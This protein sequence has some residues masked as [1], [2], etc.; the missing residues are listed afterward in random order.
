MRN[1]IAGNAASKSTS[2]PFS[3]REMVIVLLLALVICGIYLQVRA[4]QFINFD[5]L[6]YIVENRNIRD[7][8]SLEGIAWAFRLTSK[9]DWSY[10]HPIT[11]LSHMLDIELFGL[12][13][14]M[15]HLM[16]VLYHIINTTALFLVLRV[17]T[18]SLWKSG[19]VAILFGIHPVNV[20]TVAWIAERK[21][22]LSTTFWITLIVAYSSY[23]KRPSLWRYGLVVILFI[24]GLLT[25]PMLVTLP[26]V[27]LLLDYWPLGR[28]SFH[29]Q[30]VHSFRSLPGLILE[31]V[32]L[33]ALA[34]I[35]IMY[36]M[37]SMGSMNSIIGSHIVPMDLRIKNALVSYLVYL[38]KA[39]WPS[40]LTVFYPFPETIPL[41]EALTALGI[42]VAITTAGIIL[43]RRYP[44]LI[45]GWLWFLGTLLP[46]IGIIQ[47][48][49][50]PAIAERWA[51]VPYIGLFIVFAWGM[52]DCLASCRQGRAIGTGL[53]IV[54]IAALSVK[55]W[56]QT[57]YWKDDMTLF[58]HALEVDRNNPLAHQT[59]GATLYAQGSTDKAIYHYREAVRIMPSYEQAHVCLGVALYGKGMVNEAIQEYRHA[60][61]LNPDRVDT[62]YNL[63]LA[64][65]DAG[66]INE[67]TRE[68]EAVLQISPGHP[69][70]HNNLGFILARQGRLD[71]A[72][73]HYYKALD[74]RQSFDKARMNLVDAF[75]EKGEMEKGIGLMKEAA[76][77]EPANPL[78][79]IRLAEIYRKQ[80]DIVNATGA[81]E[82]ALSADR[83][84]VQ[85]LHG[86][87]VLYAEQRRYD[88]AMDMM[89]RLSFLRP[90]DPLVD[91]NISCLYARQ[92]KAVEAV[93]FI[94]K[95]MRKGFNK[96]DMLKN[97]PDLD[98][99]RD[100]KPFKDAISGS[101]R[102][103][104]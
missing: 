12:N 73:H 29:H 72:I 34:F 45:V 31:K 47:S 8:L 91:Y 97:D 82:Q 9:G 96:W 65:S 41:W 61:K 101:L 16:N 1:A 79:H 35:F 48:G 46:V 19:I 25:K 2:P 93:D 52:G 53:C 7:G 30:G 95:A 28:I 54:I 11:W 15:H 4:F 75:E 27:L 89:K 104:H 18:G 85:T 38:G 17:M 62:H 103:A 20:D 78:L 67:A 60:L 57:G 90:L 50:W 81:Y 59:L 102:A 55:S 5:D 37:Y 43:H 24:L 40:K 94:G 26:F 22:I 63:G 99:I 21:N 13:P 58:S 77:F 84:N 3:S 49:Y 70:A 83:N 14:G 66:R 64:L 39:V 87:A 36:F 23:V 6:N 80:G 98:G 88:D 33:I 86:L 44:Y 92:G 74:G 71:E 51:Y 76:D 69:D 32:P 10:W 56:H 100:T 42:L 68:Y